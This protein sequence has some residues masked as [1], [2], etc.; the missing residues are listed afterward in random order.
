LRDLDLAE[1]DFVRFGFGFAR[2]E[3]FLEVRFGGIGNFMLIA[4]HPSY[5]GE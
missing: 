3:F 1:V 2:D 4:S 5:K